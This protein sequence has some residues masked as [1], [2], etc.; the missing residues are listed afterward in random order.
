MGFLEK[1]NPKATRR[2]VIRWS[3]VGGTFGLL[4]GIL[5]LRCSDM[6]SLA[7]WFVIPAMGLGM[8]IAAGAV[9]WQLPED[10][11]EPPERDCQAL[12]R[13]AGDRT[14]GNES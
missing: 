10:E 2:S 3:V 5:M 6:P 1:Q 14:E 9:E 11:G 7:G 8:A 12:D 13:N 4:V